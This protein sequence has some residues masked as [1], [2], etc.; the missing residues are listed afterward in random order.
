LF[1]V[2]VKL[3]QFA[4]EISNV[5]LFVSDSFIEVIGEKLLI[6]G[7]SF[8]VLLNVIAKSF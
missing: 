2:A 4:S 8:A 3:S 5:K 7:S 6:T 1:N